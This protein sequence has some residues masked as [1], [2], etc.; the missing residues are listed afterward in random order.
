MCVPSAPTTTPDTHTW[1]HNHTHTDLVEELLARGAG[2]DS[3]L[4]LCIHGGDANI[5][6]ERKNTVGKA[7]VSQVHQHQRKH[8]TTKTT[9]DTVKS[10]GEAI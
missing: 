7:T 5:D 9:T 1:T 3:K 4:Q 8:K 2:Q 10:G 6:L